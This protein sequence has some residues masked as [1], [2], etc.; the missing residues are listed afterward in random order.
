[1]REIRHYV[2]S[3]GKDLFE[4]WH[5]KLRDTKL[6]VAVDRRVNRVELGNFGDHKFCREGVWELRIDFGPGIRVYYA[7]ADARIVLLLCGGDK[8]SQSADI[9]K[10]C[11][12]WREWQSREEAR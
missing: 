2:T 3:E 6:R 1:M 10:A 12:C 11:A 5:R 4:E 8:G 9:D 7:M